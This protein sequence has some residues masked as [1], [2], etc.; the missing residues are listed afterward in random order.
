[1]ADSSIFPTRKCRPSGSRRGNRHLRPAPDIVIRDGSP[2]RALRRQIP[3]PFAARIVPSG[4]HEPPSPLSN[5]GASRRGV[6]P[7]T[8]TAI[9]LVCVKNASVRLS[10]DQNGYRAAAV[11][12][13]G[14]ASGPSIDRN[15]NTVPPVLLAE[16]AI[17]RPSGDTA[18]GGT[19]RPAEFP[20][21]LPSPAG[22]SPSGGGAIENLTTGVEAPSG[23]RADRR[24]PAVTN[25]PTMRPA[26]SAA[27]I[28]GLEID[29]A[30]AVAAT[31]TVD[32]D[33]M[34]RSSRAT[35]RMLCHRSSGSLARH[36]RT[37]RSSAAGASGC[38]VVIDGGSPARIAAI[39]L[40]SVLPT[41]AFWPVASS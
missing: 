22:W 4:A 29:L 37:S 1:M 23:G 36:V 18:S 28:A 31:A 25:P 38:S 41:N 26:T 9:R 10:D 7:A 33:L 5:A 14:R 16:N 6:P 34:A 2:P 8:S 39:R 30:S 13:S 17:H 15:H 21:V 20:G 40:A 24:T 3:S 35:S 27:A 12:G 19:T 32:A 11:P